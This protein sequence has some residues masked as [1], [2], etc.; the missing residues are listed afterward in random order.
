MDYFETLNEEDKKIAQ[1]ILE[2]SVD[3]VENI[4]LNEAPT[5][6]TS[7]DYQDTQIAKLIRYYQEALTTK[8]LVDVQPMEYNNGKIFGLDITNSDGDVILGTNAVNVFNDAFSE[9]GENIDVPDIHIRLN[10]ADVDLKSRKAQLNYSKEVEQ[11]LKILKFDLD[12][13]KLKI[14][15]TEIA[16][17][18]DFDVIEA[19]AGHADFY[20]PIEY[21]WAND[22]TVTV[23]SLLTEL[24]MAIMQGAA[25]IASG[26]RK[27][28]ANFVIVPALMVQLITT[29]DRFVGSGEN[30]IG[31]VSKIGKLGFLDVYVNTFDTTTYDM[32][33][34]KKP[35]GNISSGVVLSPYKVEAG[36]LVTDY[37]DFSLHQM[38][39]NRYGI[40]KVDGG[41][42]MYFKVS[43]A[44][45]PTG[46]PFPDA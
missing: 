20:T 13:E 45:S 39:M 28:L 41:N 7:A 46:Y 8:T 21:I 17:G 38:I 31:G 26:T 24:E 1:V 44:S 18:T 9:I 35:S 5:L 43:L 32:Y 10:E 22:G 34:G 11:D 23:S 40:T 16:N 6:S 3:N 27:G 15:A 36:P 25:A 37:E 19:I 12:D 2:N 30:I 29:M 4:N 14:V 42:S 33:V